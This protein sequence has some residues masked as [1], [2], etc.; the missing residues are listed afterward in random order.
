MLL[1]YPTVTNFSQSATT[2][3]KKQTLVETHHAQGNQPN[4]PVFHSLV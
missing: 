2:V 1:D 4:T 3:A